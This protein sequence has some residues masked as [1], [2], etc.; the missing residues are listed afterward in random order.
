MDERMDGW[1]NGW[2][3]KWMDGWM[4]K[5]MNGWMNKGVDKWMDWWI[6]GCSSIFYYAHK[7]AFEIYH[8]DCHII[9]AHHVYL[10]LLLL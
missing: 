4:T 6:N 9:Y 1:K 8:F 7:G 10:R 2:M 5:W 3:D